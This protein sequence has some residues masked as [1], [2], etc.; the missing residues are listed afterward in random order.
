[1]LDAGTIASLR[2]ANEEVVVMLARQQTDLDAS[3]QMQEG[4][5]KE[6]GIMSSR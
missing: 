6:L 3:R 4:M 5:V 2:A 1:M